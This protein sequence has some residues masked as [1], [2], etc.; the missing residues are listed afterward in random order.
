MSGYEQLLAWQVA[1]RLAGEV[2]EITREASFRGHSALADQL[3]RSTVSTVS[4]VAEGHGR[5]RRA[6]FAHFLA[7]AR[8]SGV[9]TQAQLAL[10]LS[11][12]CLR[13]AEYQRLRAAADHAVALITKLHAVVSK[14][15]DPT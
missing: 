11:S 3:R 8:G 13:F 9:E 15:S 1:H 6:E 4:N 12:R 2:D 5:R 10:A 7:I 14:Q